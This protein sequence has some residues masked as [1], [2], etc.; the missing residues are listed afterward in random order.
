MCKPPPHRCSRGTNPSRDSAAGFRT[1]SCLASTW[2]DPEELAAY[3]D[4]AAA[5]RRSPVPKPRVVSGEP[6]FQGSLVFVQMTFQ[7]SSG[8]VLVDAADLTTAIAYAQRAV[9]PISR[10]ATQYGP[11]RLYVSPSVIPFTAKVPGA[12]YN[13][14]TLQGWI[15]AI[16]AQAGLPANPCIVVLNPPALLNT[17]ADPRKGVGGYHNFASVPYIFV[18]AVGRGFTVPDSANV[19]ALALS[20]EI[21]ETAVDPRADLGNPEVCDP[22]G[23]NCQT[24]WID[25]FDDRD[26]YL[27]TTQSFPPPF[28]YAY[29]INAIVRPNAATVCPAP[30]AA[31]NYAPP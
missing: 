9:V 4:L 26:G 17:D 8:S 3:P 7:T 11:N 6:L 18:N 24:V 13:D 16:V 31:C 2:P 10:Y 30:G 29:F 19:F 5:L 12:V 25:F 28:A 15:S 27:A 21:A 1:V 23:P 20:H 22:C 14:Q